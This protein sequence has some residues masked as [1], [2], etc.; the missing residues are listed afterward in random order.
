MAVD[1][2]V[3][4]D[5]GRVIPWVAG[6]DDLSPELGGE[7]IEH[8]AS[9]LPCPPIAEPFVTPFSMEVPFRGLSNV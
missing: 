2:A 7:S 4:D 9:S 1:H 8:S 6:K 5:P 3:P